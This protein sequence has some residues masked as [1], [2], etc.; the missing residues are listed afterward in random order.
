EAM[1]LI[2]YAQMKHHIEVEKLTDRQIGDLYGF[3]RRQV[4]QARV[5]DG[6]PCNPDVKGNRGGLI[7]ARLGEVAGL[8][9][10]R[11]GRLLGRSPAYIRRRRQ[12]VARKLREEQETAA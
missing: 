7:D 3:E 6:L 10:E 9:H 11:A 5:R 12:V 8:S 4:T 2:P 1:R